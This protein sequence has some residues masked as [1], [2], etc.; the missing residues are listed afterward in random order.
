MPRIQM[1]AGN[2]NPDKST[3]KFLYNLNENGYVILNTEVED[4]KDIPQQRP[5]LV[6]TDI[7]RKRLLLAWYK[8]TNNKLV[9]KAIYPGANIFDKSVY[10]VY[11][12]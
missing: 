3:N 9:S 6:F 4:N 1:I 12:E 7:S 2:F 10:E 11:S 8:D 5:S